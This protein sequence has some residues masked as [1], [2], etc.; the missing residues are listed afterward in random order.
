MKINYVFEGHGDKTIVFVHGLMDS[1]E[2]WRGL[3]SS[4][5][6]EYRTLI[7]DIRGHGDS[8]LGDDAFNIDTLVDD[9]YNL[10][11]KLGIEK[12]SLVG[13]SMGGNIVL[14]FAIRYPD[15]VDKIV[16]MS[17]YSETDDNLESILLEFKQ[18]ISI[19][20]E[21]FFDVIIRYV[22]PEKVYDQNKDALEIL[23]REKAK[24]ANIDSIKNGIDVGL[25]FNVTQ[26]LNKIDCPALILA[27]RDDDIISLEL[28]NILKSNIKNSDL[29][30]FENTKHDV[31]FGRNLLEVSE[32]LGRFF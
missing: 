19:S 5:N 31:L 2:Y 21:A 26:D 27:G 13:L 1:L 23:K 32:L 6:D 10:F 25:D 4:L 8:P 17:T 18:A 30:I 16:L 22:I 29:I 3:S 11:L 7:Y 20:Y 14:S 15:L 9:L 28:C 24:K 12:A